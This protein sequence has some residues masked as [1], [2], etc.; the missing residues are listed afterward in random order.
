MG[1]VP[2][3]YLADQEVLRGVVK[4]VGFL[5]PRSLLVIR[6]CRFLGQSWTVP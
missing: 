5:D 3:G 2:G 4:G 6:L 1:R